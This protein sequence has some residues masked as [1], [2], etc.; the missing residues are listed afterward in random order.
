MYV[1]RYVNFSVRVVKRNVHKDFFRSVIF[2]SFSY[3]RYA[4][5]I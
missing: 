2:I 4:V 3:V 5:Y 1:Y